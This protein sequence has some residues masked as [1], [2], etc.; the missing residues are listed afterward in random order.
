MLPSMPKGE[1]G[2]IVVIN[3]KGA[4]SRQRSSKDVKAK[5]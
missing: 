4:T 3:G 1:I 2:G 5:E